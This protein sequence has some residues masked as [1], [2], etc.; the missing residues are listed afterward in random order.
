MEPLG[1]PAALA[2]LTGT[3]ML[4]QTVGATRPSGRVRWLSVNAVPVPI[5]A[6]TGDLGA[7][8]SFRDITERR[9]VEAT[10]EE[11]AI[12]DPLTGL[13][14]QGSL[15]DWVDQAMKRALA[16][17]PCAS[18]AVGSRRVSFGALRCPLRSSRVRSACLWRPMSRL[19]WRSPAL[20]LR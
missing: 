14:N 8:V 4:D 11:L 17:G 10:H 6:E 18:L 13:P 5:G 3:A 16:D 12:C 2:L 20:A 1:A 9:R 7:V 15:K 19:C